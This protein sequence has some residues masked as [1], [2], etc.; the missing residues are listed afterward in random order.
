MR[1]PS[2]KTLALF[3]AVLLAGALAPFAPLATAANG[4]GGG[5]A[6]TSPG[7]SGS[8][9]GLTEMP[10][11]VLVKLRSS[12]ALP[13]LLTKY[14]LALI[15]RFGSR[16][17]YRLKIVG[18]ARLGDVLALLANDPAVLVAESNLT[19]QSPEARRNMP[20]AI[21][22]PQALAAQ[23]A[24]QAMHL[25]QAQALSSGV[26]VRVAVL[27]TGVDGSHPLLAGRL[28]PGFDFVDYDADPSEPGQSNGGAWGHGTHVAGLVALVAPGAQIM[29][30]RVLDGDGVGNAWV[31]AEAMLYALD[32]DGDP[33][34][35]DGAQIINL[36]LG[37]LART[38]IVEAVARL[39]ACAPAVADDPVNDRSDPG[40][41]ADAL[42]CANHGGSLVV[43][44]AGND[45]SSSSKQYPA[46]EGVESLVAVAASNASKHLAGFS[47]FG[48]W[49]GLAA[50]GDAITSALPGGRWG[51]WGGTSMAAP[52]VAGSAALLLAREPT[53]TPRAL[54]DRLRRTASV[55]CASQLR[56]VDPLA[57]LTNTV[58]PSASCN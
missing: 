36:S 28:L 14:G 11:E 20:W 1:Q 27:D 6:V 22:N 41:S 45:G 34:T 19:Q 53:L 31:L 25:A 21:G 23:W 10:G 39:A 40:Y 46:A 13:A 52:L 16:P 9:S 18:T 49:I 55:L 2:P 15:S 8:G 38:R 51:T 24:P 37:S 29:P 3:G 57:A 47:N 12:D 56:Q 33:A 26:G 35:N 54:I 44:A 17:I 58:P 5:S 30:L 32:P 7:S 48:S 50:P 4:P 43:A 42:R